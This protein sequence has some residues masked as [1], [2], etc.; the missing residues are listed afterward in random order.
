MEYIKQFKKWHAPQFEIIDNKPVF[1]FIFK[2]QPD[3]ENALLALQDA[4]VKEI[5]VYNEANEELTIVFTYKN[6]GE[7]S[8]ITCPP[9]VKSHSSYITF[10]EYITENPLNVYAT[11]FFRDEQKVLHALRGKI[12]LIKLDYFEIILTPFPQLGPRVNLN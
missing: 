7:G 12:A 10:K 11:T 8:V 1:G 2:E 3:A 5:R 4:E 6:S 9:I